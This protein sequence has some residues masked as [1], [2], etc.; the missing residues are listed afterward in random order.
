MY[1]AEDTS[2]DVQTSQESMCCTQ[3]DLPYA[4]SHLMPQ[5]LGVF[6]TRSQSNIMAL[7][8]A[9]ELFFESST[10]KE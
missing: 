6:K 10:Y 9:W 2:Q 4:P 8:T 7:I 3:L 5:D 1:R